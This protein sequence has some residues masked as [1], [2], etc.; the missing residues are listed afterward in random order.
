MQVCKISI[1]T[2]FPK[3]LFFNELY[4]LLCLVGMSG[5]SFLLPQEYVFADDL[6]LVI[7]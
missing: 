4:V 3:S 7:I 5:I 2:K 6:A 1:L